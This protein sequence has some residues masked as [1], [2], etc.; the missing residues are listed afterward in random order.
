MLLT[1]ESKEFKKYGYVL[2]GD[3]SDIVSFLLS[4]ARMPE[5]NNLYVRDDKSML[6]CKSISKI[7]EKVF[8]FGNIETG[9]CNGYNS[10]LNC[11]EYHNAPEVDIAANDL[12]LLLATQ[13]DVK[14]GFIDSK[15]VKAFLV[16]KGTCVVLNPFTFHFSP[17]KLSDEGFKCAIILPDGTNK[18][19]D[20]PV[21]DKKLWK[22]NKWLF[23]HEE[24][25]QAKIGAYIG[26]KGE[27]IEIKY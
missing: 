9:Y 22:E 8:G 13:D 19:L 3:Y 2:E 12:V 10:K 7:Q 15:D 14:D 24:S 1:T 23:A 20:V 27:N 5:A 6:A 11:L 16:K 4:F 18:D 21:E 17:C 26:I 25:N